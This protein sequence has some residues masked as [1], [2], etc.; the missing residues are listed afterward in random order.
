[1]KKTVSFYTLGCRLNQAETAILER[2]F[3]R[4][5]Y[6]VVDFQQPADVVVINTC[7]VTANTETDTR[8]L[9]HKINR[10]NNK[11]KI[12]LI[13]CQAQ[14]QKENLLEL[15]GVFWVIGNAPKMELPRLLNQFNHNLPQVLVPAIPKASFKILGAG[16]DRKHTR[17]NLK[18][19]D[20]CDSFCSFCVV[21]YARGRARSRDFAD[22]LREAGELVVAGHRELVLTGINVGSYQNQGKSIVDV[23]SALELLADLQR[24]RIS[25]IEPTSIPPGLMAK[26]VTSQKLCRY[27][28]LPLQSGNDEILQAMNRKYTT[29]EFSEFVFKARQS[30]PEICL[31]ADVI[32][33]FPGE[34]EADFAVTYQLLQELPL[35]YFH[36]FSY[37]DRQ[38]TPSSRLANKVP[39]RL[40]EDRSRQLRQLGIRKRHSYLANFIG[41]DVSVLFEQKKDDWWHGLT[42]TYIRVLVKSPL[43]LNNQILPVRLEQ[44]EKQSMIGSLL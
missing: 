18:I 33:G 26:M 43:N 3:E 36:V 41:K 8:R 29:A 17:A 25:S 44:I 34:S 27:L 31:G 38:Q 11:A 42:D 28:H 12:A 5:G 14:V 30:I 4:D 39:A 16:I 20:G 13:G 24:V 40:I 15:P 10:L 2:S 37:S 21:P 6:A 32:V 23:I 7:T 1:M 19:Q 22:L 35:T 9:V